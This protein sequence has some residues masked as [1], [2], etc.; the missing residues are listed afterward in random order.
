MRCHVKRH[1]KTRP[2]Q[3][4]TKD[5]GDMPAFVFQINVRPLVS[6]CV[7]TEKN[8]DHKIDNLRIPTE[9]MTSLENEMPSSTVILKQGRHNARLKTLEI[10]LLLFSK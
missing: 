8:C 3:C 9:K 4:A 10:Y 5:V 6:K 7:N 1:L 2:T